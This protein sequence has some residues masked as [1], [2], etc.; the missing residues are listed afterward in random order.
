[1]IAARILCVVLFVVTTACAPRGT[2]TV[3]PEAAAIGDVRPIFLATSRAMA[4]LPERFAGE[5]GPLSYARYD[6]SVPP[7]RKQGSIPF[8]D[9]DKIDPTRQML[10]V[11]E[12]IYASKGDFQNALSKSLH[13]SKSARRV[14]VF[15]HGFNNTYAEGLYRAAKWIIG[16]AVG[17]DDVAG[18]VLVGGSIEAGVSRSCGN[19]DV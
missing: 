18:S 13:G 9:T 3:A 11:D 19:R 6:V 2:I 16:A 15:V 5:R 4:D 7:D 1:M 8:P 12:Q 10:T 17:D 14:I